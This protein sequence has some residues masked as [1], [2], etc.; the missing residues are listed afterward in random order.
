MNI[1][2]LAIDTLK[3]LIPIILNDS[4]RFQNCQF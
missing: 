4:K 3:S 1:E 2:F